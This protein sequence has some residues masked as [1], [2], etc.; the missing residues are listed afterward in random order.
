[1]VYNQVGRT[2]SPIFVTIPSKRELRNNFK[3]A[4]K[5]LAGNRMRRANMSTD[6]QM[7]DMGSSL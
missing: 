7:H 3:D 6:M 5:T 1:M 2:N 4:S